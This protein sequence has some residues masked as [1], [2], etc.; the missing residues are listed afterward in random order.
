MPEFY[1]S[2]DSQA[3][4]N[5][6]ATARTMLAQQGFKRVSFLDWLFH[7]EEGVR[8]SILKRLPVLI[9]VAGAILRIIGTAS[10]AIWND[11]ANMLYRTTIPFLTLWQE[12]SE[13]SGD[14]LLEILLRP[15]MAISHSLWLLRLPS[16]LAGVISLFLVYKLM[17]RLGFNFR[18]QIATA[19]IT[20]FLPGLIWIAQD[21]RTYSLL[22]CLFLAALWFALESGWIGLL[23]VCGLMIYTHRIGAVFSVSALLICLYVFQWKANKILKVGLLTL[24]AWIPAVVY[25]ILQWA[26]QQPWQPHLIFSWFLYSSIR[27]FWPELYPDW[28]Y[29]LSSLVFL[30]TLAYL[31]SRVTAFC[32]IVPLMAWTIPLIGLIAFSLLTTNVILYRT[33]Q[34]V[35][36]PFALWLG[37]EIGSERS[38]RFYRFPYVWSIMLIIGL[39]F[40]HPAQRGAGLDLVAAEIRSQWRTGDRLVYATDTVAQPFNYYLGDLPHEWLTVVSN[41]FLFSPGHVHNVPLP[42]GTLHRSWVIIPNDGLI[43][44]D[45]E[46]ILMDMVHHQ[47]P[48]FKTIVF[49]QNAPIDVYLV[50]EP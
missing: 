39:M 44:P 34:P 21:A 24:V 40:W 1:L 2:H 48:V 38:F 14:L 11:E 50:E 16:M 36:F 35:L 15:L 18:Q 10:S 7:S 5:P 43:T 29:L 30:R 12:G 32:R 42:Q 19:T 20:S 8:A 37:W 46:T 17:V 3:T 27:A 47:R 22:A 25:I 49:V 45:E 41:P 33:I 26:I 6:D 28:F 23:A 13:S 4:G 31:F 9:L